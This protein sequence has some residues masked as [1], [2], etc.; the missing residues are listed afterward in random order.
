[1]KVTSHPGKTVADVCGDSGSDP[2]REA[3]EA[4]TLFLWSPVLL[5]SALGFKL[6]SIN[7]GIL[8]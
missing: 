3:G 5:L 8:E 4:W 2:G 6:K 7:D 1:M